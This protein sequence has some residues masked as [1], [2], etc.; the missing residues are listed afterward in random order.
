MVAQDLA[1]CGLQ[2]AATNAFRAGTGDEDAEWADVIAAIKNVK[3]TSLPTISTATVA[4]GDYYT[5][6]FI[7]YDVWSGTVGTTTSFSASHPVTKTL[8][9]DSS[10][11]LTE[12]GFVSVPDLD[13]ANKGFVARNGFNEGAGSGTTKC[14]GAFGNLA[15]AMI[16]AGG[17]ANGGIPPSLF[18]KTSGEVTLSGEFE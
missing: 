6:P 9:A 10:V 2:I 17:N 13:D 4:A 1:K 8:G 3:R 15:P 14:L 16:A 11:F 7:E 18:S 5:T 12:L